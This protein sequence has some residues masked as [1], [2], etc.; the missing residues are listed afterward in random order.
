MI[1]VIDKYHSF[2]V[3]YELSIDHHIFEYITVLLLDGH[4]TMDPRVDTILRKL[5]TQKL[6]LEVL[7]RV[8]L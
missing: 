6:T 8:D 2:F 4:Q 7:L 3:E 1:L 5:L